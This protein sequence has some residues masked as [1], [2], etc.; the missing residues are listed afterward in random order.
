V[1]ETRGES[2]Q[3]RATVDKPKAVEH[4]QQGNAARARWYIRAFRLFVRSLFHIFFRIRVKGLGNVPHTPAIICVNHL[5]WTDPFL[6]L[7]FFPVEPRAYVLGEQEVKYISNFR[8]QVIDFLEIMVM[9]DRS[10]PVQALRIMQDVLKRGGSLVIFPE[11]HL[12]KQEGALLELQQGAAHL[13]QVSGV[14]LLPVG[15]TGTSE[16]WLRRTLTMR[17]GKPIEPTQFEGDTRTRMHAMTAELDR[18]MHTLLPG[19]KERARVKLLKKW[20][21][22]LF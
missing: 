3:A 15:L 5:G 12:G 11:G 8:T 7:L 22:N 4:L 20:L 19:D 2:E 6:V 13:S 17:I 21:T 14:P 1:N 10:K 16:L 9:L 18:R